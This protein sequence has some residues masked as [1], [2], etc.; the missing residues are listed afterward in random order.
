MEVW[1]CRA[2][3]LAT[4]FNTWAFSFTEKEREALYLT[5]NDIPVRSLQEMTDTKADNWGST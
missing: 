4:T 2:V 5:N 1:F 3:T